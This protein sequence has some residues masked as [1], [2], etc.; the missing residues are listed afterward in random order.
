MKKSVPKIPRFLDLENIIYIIAY[1]FA[2]VGMKPE[3]P[4]FNIFMHLYNNKNILEYAQ[5]AQ[6]EPKSMILNIEGRS[7]I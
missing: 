3:L 5:I 4:F 1:R 2:N 6:S 7:N